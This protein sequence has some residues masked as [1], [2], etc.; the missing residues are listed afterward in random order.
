M[1]EVAKREAIISHRNL[2]PLQ[3]NHIF[4]EYDHFL[5]VVATA[6]NYIQ[7]FGLIESKIRHFLT[8]IEK[9]SYLYLQ[10]AR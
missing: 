1:V 7:W 8:S 5:V 2:S 10:A 6:N 3:T 9:E 4:H